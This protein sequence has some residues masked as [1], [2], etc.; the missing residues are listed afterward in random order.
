MSEAQKETGE[1]VERLQKDIEKLR[2]DINALIRDF[3]EVGT[4][5]G[6]A[7]FDRARRAG[8]SFL[9]DAEELRKQADRKI[10]ENPLMS[11]LVSFG[12][13]FVVGKLLDRRR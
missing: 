5:Q 3:R 13:G 1:D 8:E 9:S 6:K 7:A 11:V 2:A 4:E 12:V 10:E